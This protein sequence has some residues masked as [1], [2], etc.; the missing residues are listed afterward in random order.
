MIIT[1][2]ITV[3]YKDLKEL[4]IVLFVMFVYVRGITIVSGKNIKCGSLSEISPIR[5]YCHN[6]VSKQHRFWQAFVRFQILQTS[7]VLLGCLS[8]LKLLILII[9][10]WIS[11]G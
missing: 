11:R 3:S 8:P 10:D 6:C 5:R 1:T 2:V 4:D 9:L 7:D